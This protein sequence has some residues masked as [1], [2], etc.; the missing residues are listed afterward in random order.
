MSNNFRRPEDIFFNE[1]QIMI[2]VQVCK[3][4]LQGFVRPHR[5]TGT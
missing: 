1:M 2:S 4:L 3:W 5:A